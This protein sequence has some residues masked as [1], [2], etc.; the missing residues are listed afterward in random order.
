MNSSSSSPRHSKD[1]WDDTGEEWDNEAATKLPANDTRHRHSSQAPGADD[2]P[3]STSSPSSLRRRRHKTA[4]YSFVGSLRETW[5]NI[6]SLEIVLHLLGLLLFVAVGTLFY[7]LGGGDSVPYGFNRGFYKAVSVGYAIGWVYPEE[8]TYN[9]QIFSSIYN[10]SGIFVLAYMVIYFSY[11]VFLFNLRWDKRYHIQRSAQREYER[12]LQE[13]Q[14]NY[15]VIAWNYIVCWYWSHEMIFNMGLMVGALISTLWTFACYRYG[16]GAAT[17]FYFAVSCVSTSGTVTIPEDAADVDYI[18]VAA[19]TAVGIP[20]LNVALLG[21][22]L[23]VFQA[24]LFCDVVD[25]ETLQGVTVSE[26]RAMRSLGIHSSAGVPVEPCSNNDYVVLIAMRMGALDPELYLR[27]SAFYQKLDRAAKT[28]EAPPVEPAENGVDPLREAFGVVEDEITGALSSPTPAKVSRQ[29]SLPAIVAGLPRPKVD[30][31]A[32][33][34]DGVRPAGMGAEGAA[35]TAGRHLI[36]LDLMAS[37]AQQRVLLRESRGGGSA[38]GSSSSRE[39]RD[40]PAGGSANADTPSTAAGPRAEGGAGVLSTYSFDTASTGSDFSDTEDE[41][42]A[43]GASLQQ[44]GGDAGGG[45]GTE[46]SVGAGSPP[47]FGDARMR[48]RGAGEEKG[49]DAPLIPGRGRGRGGRGRGGSV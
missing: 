3:S 25:R 2:P 5:R 34:G 15:I 33:G 24:T 31:G 45:A 21:V 44:G 20:L 6:S 16:W 12:G 39:G 40:I 38:R 48:A 14:G 47:G 4:P 19:L 28:G 22:L 9:M 26:L 18:V 30:G 17:G 46:G 11:K 23:R 29:A 36:L 1:T 35:G 42:G 49:E 10:I 7:S 43:A 13:Y 32:S 27:I 8:E 37:G 41:E